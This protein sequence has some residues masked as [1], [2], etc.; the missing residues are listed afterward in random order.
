MMGAIIG[1]IVGSRFEFNNTN[2]MDF[3]LFTPE[4]DYTDDTICT[5]AIADAILNGKS[6]KD[7]LLEWCRV[8]PHPKGGYGGSFS[9]W[10]QSDDPQPYNSW[11]NGSA[12]RVSPVGWVYQ[13]LRDTQIAAEQTAVVTH[14][15]PEG[16]KGAKAVADAVYLAIRGQ[17]KDYIKN[18]IQ[19]NYG[20]DLSKST[21]DIRPFYTFNESC[22]GSVP[23]AIVCFLESSDFE[24]A[25]RLAVSIRGDSD[26]IAAI[27]GSIAEAFY[28][29]PTHIEKAAKNYLPEYMID[30]INEFEA[31]Y[32]KV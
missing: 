10:I 29:V 9:R 20:Y 12:M 23:E 7:S 27:T 19:A 16:I 26:T 11:G 6:Y 2:R 4:C 1:D 8:Y 5:V 13:A 18:H 17:D 21:E 30:V 25:I 28:G 3:E 22:Q 14:N 15:H 32:G 31:K 24:Q